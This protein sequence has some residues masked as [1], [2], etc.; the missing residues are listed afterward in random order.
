MTKDPHQRKAF[1]MSSTAIL[2][3]RTVLEPARPHGFRRVSRRRALQA[4]AQAA[5]DRG[6]HIFPC[7]PNGKAPMTPH[8][9][10]DAEPHARVWEPGSDS[11]Y[12]RNA[13]IGI[14]CGASGLL[15]VDLDVKHAI[16]G[17]TAFED[18][19][20]EWPDTYEVETPSGGVHLYF[21]DP[22]NEFGCGTGSLPE[23]IDIRG[24]GGY[25][26]GAG[27][28]I[29]GKRYRIVN[30]ADVAPIP[31]NLSTALL[32]PRR[33]IVRQRSRHRWKKWET[34]PRLQVERALNQILERVETARPGE[35]NNILHWA[36]C[37]FG[38]AMDAGWITDET[39]EAA[40]LDAAWACGLVADD[41]K[42]TTLGTIYSGLDD[43]NRR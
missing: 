39:A 14:A 26:L 16:D 4:A 29:D 40:L 6:W 9:F 20:G 22:D 41:G 5:V 19:M 34:M 15:V 31:E 18:F 1:L 32:E 21:S 12:P 27:S 43:R 30:D 33:R 25:V 35:R 7:A 11:D 38:E 2:P 42:Y 23:G 24:K 13:N 10:Q 17:I 8:G 3:D 36:A 37:R 28:V